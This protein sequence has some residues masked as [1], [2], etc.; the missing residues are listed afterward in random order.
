MGK[1]YTRPVCFI[2]S[3]VWF[4][5]GVCQSTSV[6]VFTTLEFLSRGNWNFD[7]KISKLLSKGVIVNTLEH[8]RDFFRDQKKA[9][10]RMILNL[11]I[12]NGFLNFKHCKLELV[13]NALYLM[14]EGCYFGSV[15]LKDQFY[16]I[17][18]YENY[19]KYLKLFCKEEYYQ[20]ILLTNGFSPA[21]RVFTNAWHLHL[22]I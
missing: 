15:E 20:N 21:L 22:N 9:N 18:I 3:K 11:K 10:D 16:T 4:N 14:T 5:N 19:Q 2:C 13:K 7:A 1:Y 8:F 17:P 6:L 12:F